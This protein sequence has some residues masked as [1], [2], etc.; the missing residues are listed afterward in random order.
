MTRSDG[1]PKVSAQS[2]LK[3]REGDALP[4]LGPVEGGTVEEASR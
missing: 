2:I 3:A 4:G 1:R